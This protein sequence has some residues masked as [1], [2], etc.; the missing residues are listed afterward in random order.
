MGLPNSLCDMLQHG[1]LGTGYSHMCRESPLP[2]QS[3]VS[4]LSLI[5]SPPG[6]SVGLL[7]NSVADC[8]FASIIP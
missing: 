3:R 6:N 2:A 4:V 8:H 1:E 7:L 5:I